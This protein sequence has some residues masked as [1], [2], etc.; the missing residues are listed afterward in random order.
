[1]N[2]EDGTFEAV[3]NK[4]TKGGNAAGH[5]TELL[6]AKGVEILLAGKC[7]SKALELLDAAGIQVVPNCSGTVRAVVEQFKAKQLPPADKTQAPS[8]SV[9]EK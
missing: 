3:E 9:S 8:E 1:M 7:A 5:A 2:P 6:A 4:D